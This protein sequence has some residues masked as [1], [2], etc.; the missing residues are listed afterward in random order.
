MQIHIKNQLNNGLTMDFCCGAKE[1]TL[2]HDEEIDIEVNDGDCM[3]FDVVLEDGR[4]SEKEFKRLYPEYAH[5]WDWEE[6][7]E[8]YE[9]T[10][11]CQ[12]CRSYSD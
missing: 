1:Y 7:P 4:M 2:A 8:G 9:G 11:A 12:L 5:T 6:H 10:C 3:Y